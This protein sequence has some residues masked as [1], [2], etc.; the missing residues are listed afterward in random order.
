MLPHPALANHSDQTSTLCHFSSFRDSTYTE[1]EHSN[2]QIDQIFEGINRDLVSLAASGHLAD[3]E[4]DCGDGE[5]ES[6]EDSGEEGGAGGGRGGHPASHS[7]QNLSSFRRGP[8]P[9]S[10]QD[11]RSR[12]RAEERGRRRSEKKVRTEKPGSWSVL[13]SHWSVSQN[14]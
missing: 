14:C 6:G 13:A 11:R 7:A 2:G 10:R 4:G 9:T 1:G 8:A 5:A 12:S 3:S